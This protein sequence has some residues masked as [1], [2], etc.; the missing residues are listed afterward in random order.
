VRVFRILEAALVVVL[1]LEDRP[2]IED[3]DEE[4]DE[5]GWP[6]ANLKHAG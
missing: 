3:E 6:A 4:D 5:Y 1:V 2:K